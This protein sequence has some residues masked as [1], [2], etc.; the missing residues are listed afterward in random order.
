MLEM[1][2]YRI[3]K[4]LLRYC[5]KNGVSNVKTFQNNL[6]SMVRKFVTMNKID[7][8]NWITNCFNSIR[9]NYEWRKTLYQ[10]IV[11]SAILNNNYEL[12]LEH[13]EY[14]NAN[15][16]NIN[17]RLYELTSETFVT[18]DPRIINYLFET[19]RL[20]T[21]I[22][23]YLCSTN[24][25][26]LLIKYLSS[27]QVNYKYIHRREPHTV[28]F[29]GNSIVI[30]NITNKEKTI[31]TINNNTRHGGPRTFQPRLSRDV[32]Y[33]HAHDSIK[34][35]KKHTLESMI[36]DFYQKLYYGGDSNDVAIKDFFV[37]ILNK[38]LECDNQELAYSLC[39]YYKDIIEDVKNNTS[40]FIEL[41][42]EFEF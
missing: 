34:D 3:K 17:L 37:I 16:R 4:Q 12:F 39:D 6:F 29:L 24:N 19:N 38:I 42:Y 36:E 1:C 7:A 33:S 8:I 41:E 25:L 15:Y 23:Q 20:P 13:I 35:D 14:L 10:F 22:F 30:T 9:D 40:L 28:E 31:C 26:E 27:V 32:I 2:L 18:L 11:C 21:D 5:K